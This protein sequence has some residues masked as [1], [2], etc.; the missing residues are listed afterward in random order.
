MRYEM[1][2]LEKMMYYDTD[3]VISSYPLYI[4]RLKTPVNRDALRRAMDIAIRCYPL[5]GCR[6]REDEK[7]PY[8][9]TNPEPP[10]LFDLSP[11]EPLYYGGQISHHYPWIIGVRGREII[12]TGFHGLTDGMGATAFMRTVFYYYFRECGTPCAPGQAML[13]E[14]LTPALLA[15]TTE[16]STAEN[17]R[18]DA[19]SLVT[20]PEI[21]GTV[22]PDE[23]YESDPENNRIY[24]ISMNLGQIRR[25]AVQSEVSQ[26]AVITPLLGEAFAN[27]LPGSENKIRM[28]VIADRRRSLGSL[29]TH[30]CVQ[31]IPI[32]YDQKRFRGLDDD[33]LRTVFRARLDLCFNDEEIRHSCWKMVQLER[34]IGGSR[35]ALAGAAAALTAQSGLNTPVAAVTYTH[36]THL[37]FPEDML[38][39]FEEIYINSSGQTIPNKAAIPVCN[40]VTAGDQ[41]HFTI[42][43]QLK[44]HPVMTQFLQKLR[45][46]GIDYRLE[47]LEKYR[48][49]HWRR[50]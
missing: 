34:R 44:D 33:L 17:G 39:R 20:E 47:E 21:R 43:E 2:I 25:E 24:K 3:G 28:N 41:I 8:L 5:F 23:L 37:D 38:D 32:F 12:Y 13:L 27:A 6:L 16:R 9:E 30:N 48:G 15:K 36:L 29:T 4:Y 14:R 11:S 22:I 46:R 45:Q 26:F 42:G 31:S 40:P 7:G 10:V 19:P 49:I 18:E 35:Q 50:D 1:E